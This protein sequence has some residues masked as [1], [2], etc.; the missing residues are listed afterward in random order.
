MQRPCRRP[1]HC[2]A[3]SRMPKSKAV[4]NATTQHVGVQKFE[5]ANLSVRFIIPAHTHMHKYTPLQVPALSGRRSVS[6]W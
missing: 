4:W 2:R 3:V 6:T 1:S 5:S